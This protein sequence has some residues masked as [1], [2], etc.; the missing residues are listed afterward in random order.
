MWD[1][2]LTKKKKVQYMTPSCDYS[3]IK[4]IFQYSQVLTLVSVAYG[5]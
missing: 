5:C 2:Q 3:W 1:R 4:A